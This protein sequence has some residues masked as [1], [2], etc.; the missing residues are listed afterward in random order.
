[1]CGEL[2]V[3][4]ELAKENVLRGDSEINAIVNARKQFEFALN[5]ALNYEY[6]GVKQSKADRL[7]E[8]YETEMFLKYKG[9]VHNVARRYENDYL[10]HDDM[11]QEGYFVLLECIRNYDANT[12]I[13]FR[14]YCG[15]MVWMRMFKLMCKL[16]D[17]RRVRQIVYKNGE[18]QYYKCGTAKY[19]EKVEFIPKTSIENKI[20]DTGDEEKG[21]REVK[22][23]STLIFLESGYD[24]FESNDSIK[25]IL[26]FASTLKSKRYRNIVTILHLKMEGMTNRQIGKMYNCTGACISKTL[27]LFGQEY[28]KSIGAMVC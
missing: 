8:E 5:E 4:I 14:N 10:Y 25:H 12:G 6:K 13:P 26:N 9:I 23:E 21:H 27:Q 17:S 7:R 15:K 16:R 24:E 1:M 20:S 28:K 11:I 22:V 18:K 2:G 3:I 19:V